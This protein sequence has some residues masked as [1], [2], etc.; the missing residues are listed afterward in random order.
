MPE[1]AMPE[2]AMPELAMPELAM[3]AS[4]MHAS[5]MHASPMHAS[6]RRIHSWVRQF[7]NC[8]GFILLRF[9]GIDPQQGQVITS[10]PSIH[11]QVADAILFTKS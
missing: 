11:N 5:P 9:I 8:I 2:L 3:H 1:L 4:P 7:I 10:N 6:S